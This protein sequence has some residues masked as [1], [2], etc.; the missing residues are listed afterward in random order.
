MQHSAQTGSGRRQDRVPLGVEIDLRGLDQSVLDASGVSAS[1]ELGEEALLAADGLNVS[2]GGIAMRA[3]FVPPLG[4]LLECSFECPPTGELVCAQG[5]VVWS[6][7][8]GPDEGQFGLRFVELDTK[9]ATALRRF[10]APANIYE[11]KAERAR[12]ATLVIDGLG[13]VVEAELKLADDSRLVLEQ[14]LSFL[15][16]G[17]GVEV[18]L[19]GRGKERGRIAS[20]ELRHTHFDVPTL[21]FGVLL[22]ELPERS[23][24]ERVQVER[25]EAA[26]SKLAPLF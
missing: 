23:V 3:G 16:L 7:R 12:A 10:V 13:T 24:S 20:V 8:C 2:I 22:D 1:G 15:Q 9:S 25:F 21:V 14:Q 18:Q 26:A 5:E 4:T 11:V 6:E 17:R 19:P